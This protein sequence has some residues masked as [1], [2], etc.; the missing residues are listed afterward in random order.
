MQLLFVFLAAFFATCVKATP[1]KRSTGMV[2]LPLRR[3]EL[4]ALDLHPQLLLQH[5]IN[6]A[7]RRLARMTGRAEPCPAELRSNLNKRVLSIEASASQLTRRFN[8][9]NVPGPVS[10][11]LNTV[12]SST[13]V[14]KGKKGRNAGTGS[15][16]GTTNS[17]SAGFSP[18]D[19]NAPSVST[20][21]TPTTANSLG[22]DIDSADLGYLATIQMGTPPQDFEILMDS[23]S[24]DLWVGSTNCQSQT[25]GGCG[26]H[27][28][29]GADTSSS[30]VDSNQPF[31]ITYGTGNVAG[32]IITD[33]IVV[34]GLSLTA[35]KFGVATSESVE[36]SDDS[37]PFSGLMGLAQ[38]TLSQQSTLTPVES[39][40]KAGLI[41]EAI[42]SYKIS[43][44][45]DQKNDGEIT[46]GGLDE[47]KFDAA[48]LTTVD[49]VS[50]QGFWEADM[51]SVTV[52]GKDTGLAGR[53]AIL[54][55]GTTLIIVP[56]GDAAAIHALIPGAQSDGQGG[57]TVPCTTTA[58]IALTFGKTAFAIDPRDIAVSPVDPNN[59]TGDCVSGFSSGNIG[60]ATEW[61]VGDVFLKNAYFSTN[62]GKNTISLAKLV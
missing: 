30:F 41:K 55:T 57:F 21:N 31:N 4:S 43:R 46:F 26:N 39:L 2:S 38:S 25:G 7:S 11:T 19:L 22:L 16:A 33:D 60:G 3:M 52:D 50:K 8:R 62:V 37:V 35:H 18:I 29:L 61:L 32:N 40:A 36:F 1:T 58:S 53:T 14:F 23:G 10:S 24:A 20:A 51:P 15:T 6:R 45:A 54:D 5:R 44:L 12:I 27:T 13:K 49:N 59:L 28:F 42:T 48:T 9:K 47:T 17:T 34:A 56:A